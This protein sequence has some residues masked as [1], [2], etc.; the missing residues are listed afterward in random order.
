VFFIVC[1]S[2]LGVEGGYN[3]IL[4]ST[5]DFNFLELEAG[6]SNLELDLGMESELAKRRRHHAHNHRSKHGHHS[7]MSTQ[8]SKVEAGLNIA[9]AEAEEMQMIGADL[10]HSERVKMEPKRLLA[11]FTSWSVYGRKY[12]VT[13]VPMDK[14]TH[15][16]YAFANIIDGTCAVGDVYADIDKAFGQDNFVQPLRGSIH[17]LNNVSKATN[18]HLRSLISI[19]G[20]EWSKH[21]SDVALTSDTREKFVMGCADFMQKYGFDGIDIDWEFPVAGGLPTNIYRKA[22]TNNFVKLVKRFREELDNRGNF[23][24]TVAGPGGFDKFSNLKLKEMEPYL[25]WFNVMTYDYNGCWSNVTSHHTPMYPSKDDPTD[26]KD[27]YNSDYSL[28]AYK[29]A[30]IPSYKLGIGAAF[31]GR[32]FGKVNGTDE[33][34]YL[35]KDFDAC[36]KGTWDSWETG[37]TGTYDY[38]DIKKNIDENNWTRYWDKEAKSP[39]VV[40]PDV[41]PFGRVMISYDDPQSL[42]HKV[43]YVHDND[44]GGVFLWSLDGDADNELINSL[45][46]N[47]DVDIYRDLYR[48]VPQHFPDQVLLEIDAAAAVEGQ[49]QFGDMMAK[50]KR[51]QA[52]V[53]QDA[54][55]QAIEAQN[56]ELAKASDDDSETVGGKKHHKKHNKEVAPGAAAA[57]QAMLDRQEAM[58]SGVPPPPPSNTDSDSD[59]EPASTS[60]Y[61]NLPPSIQA[62]VDAQN[63]LQAQEAELV[64]GVSSVAATS[65]AQSGLPA[66]IEAQVQAQ[67]RLVMQQQEMLKGGAGLMDPILQMKRM[68]QVQASMGSTGV[69]SPDV[70]LTDPAS[71]QTAAIKAMTALRVQ[72]NADGF[73]QEKLV[74]SRHI[75]HI[76]HGDKRMYST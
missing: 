17:Q 12:P 29:D 5:D 9:R 50:E 46:D 71:L 66:A 76:H 1:L 13:D 74:F 70:Q 2:L 10:G 24:L 43:E 26:L 21:Y 34:G 16:N 42:K 3:N 37:N 32:G 25:D 23:Y 57:L 55:A 6:R 61:S 40:S 27:K 65:S 8:A 56:K 38:S 22:D 73:I 75:P 18:P 36:P 33:T 54:A 49:D 51:A 59:D 31:Y 35:Y 30:G 28:Q 63:A 58:N 11:Y 7:H 62:Q 67:N 14:L 64:A 4:Q 68:A 44:L 15:V 60:V 45:Y 19:G 52:E 48:A 47:L 72:Q 53:K 69:A 39:Y 41:A 20:W